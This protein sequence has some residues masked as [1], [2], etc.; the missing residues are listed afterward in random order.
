[1]RK[2]NYILSKP[3]LALILLIMVVFCVFGCASIHS[4]AVRDLIDIETKKLNQANKNSQQFI[5]ATDQ[6]IDTWR[7]SVETLSKSLQKQRTVE[8]VH[9]LVFSANQNIA[10][11]T[12]VDAHAAG[13]LIGELYLA[14]RM[15]LEQTVLDQFNEDFETL[16]KLGNKISDSW[17][18]LEKTHKE[19]DAFSKRTALASVDT[20]LVSALLVEFEVDAEAI[21]EVLKRS[22]QVNEALKKAS[23]LGY[24][25]GLESGRAQTV[26]EDVINLLERIKK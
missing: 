7:K 3:R 26:I 13:Y 15:G 12:G 9:L 8:S 25:E 11:K 16:T 1:M 20:K 22:K 10:T 24:L 6:A 21:N 19:I 14:D 5:K 2:L 23:G 18:A 4:K 17:K